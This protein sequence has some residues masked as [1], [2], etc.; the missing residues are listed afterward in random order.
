MLNNAY[1]QGIIAVD[2]HVHRIA[3]LLNIINT[4]DEK[5]SSK[6]LN[7]IVPRKCRDDFN[8]LIVAFGQTICTIKNPKCDICSIKE[9][10]N[11]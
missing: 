1:S 5:E 9:Y 4:K 6:V 2:T 7:E 10:C 3:N 11:I 8:F